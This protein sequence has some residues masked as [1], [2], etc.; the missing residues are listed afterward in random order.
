MERNHTHED[1]ESIPLTVSHPLEVHPE[2]VS[3][4]LA[5]IEMA[6]EVTLGCVL[7]VTTVCRGT[8]LWVSLQREF[9]STHTPYMEAQRTAKQLL[10]QVFEEFKHST[11]GTSQLHTTHSDSHS[12]GNYEPGEFPTNHIIEHTLLAFQHLHTR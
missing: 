10:K 2:L 1:E 12:G 5:Q 7:Y 9:I 4:K 6:L 3:T 11:V 8:T